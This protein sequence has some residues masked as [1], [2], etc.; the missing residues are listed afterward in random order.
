MGDSKIEEPKDELTKE[1][2]KAIEASL[3]RFRES[4]EKL[5]PTETKQGTCVVCS[6]DV[7][8]VTVR[9]RQAVRRDAIGGP[10]HVVTVVKPGYHCTSCG[11]R[12]EFPPKAKEDDQATN[13][14]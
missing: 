8:K 2:R 6:G 12:Y 11:L 3:K 4:R 5:G 7:V 14:P 10:S 1:Q 9:Q 13:R